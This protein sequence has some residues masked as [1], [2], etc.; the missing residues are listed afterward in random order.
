MNK[1]NEWTN[2]KNKINKIWYEINE[3][4]KID[5]SIHLLIWYQIYLM[6]LYFLFYCLLFCCCSFYFCGTIVNQN[7]RKTKIEKKKKFLFKKNNFIGNKI[8][9]ARVLN[10]MRLRLFVVFT[11]RSYATIMKCNV[12]HRRHFNFRRKSEKKKMKWFYSYFDNENWNKS[13]HKRSWITI[14]RILFFF[15]HIS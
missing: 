10:K 12:I 2:N 11:V 15:S 5:P 1:S 14:F 9:N 4:T 7:K 8:M 6:F 3:V 13:A